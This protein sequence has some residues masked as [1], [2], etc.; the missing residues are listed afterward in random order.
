[1]TDVPQPGDPDGPEEE[2]PGLFGM[3]G[4]PGLDFSQLDLA[5]VMR[6]LRERPH[7]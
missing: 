6:L 1:M 3:P 2:G 7:R 5:Q 4:L